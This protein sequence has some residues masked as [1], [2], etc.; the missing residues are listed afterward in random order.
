M[1]YEHANIHPSV[2]VRMQY[3]FQ[4]QSTSTGLDLNSKR[5]YLHE[6]PFSETVCES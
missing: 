1:A 2:I 6:E 3:I 4:A 5:A